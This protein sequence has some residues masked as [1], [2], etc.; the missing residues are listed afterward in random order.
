M[1]T[2]L[3]LRPD[4][5]FEGYAEAYAET[6][7]V[8]I[9]DIF[10]E[11][12][13]RYLAQLFREQ[14]AWRLIATD[15]RDN[16]VQFTQDQWRAL[17]EAERRRV[18]QGALA[19]AR[20]NRGFLYN[21]YQMIEAYLGRRDQGHP[22]HTLT[23][24]LNGPDWLGLGQAVLRNPAITKAD[25]HATLYAPG[26]Y[27]TRHTDLG[28]VRE[29][30]AAYVIGLTERWEADWGG[31]LLF[32]DE[33]GDV[34][35]GYAPRFNVVTIFDVEKVHLVTQV[36]NF[37]GAGRYSVAGWFRDDPPVRNAA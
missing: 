20:E 7:I 14:I 6:G 35:R 19:R 33:R 26:H 12:A 25:A 9:P 17:G 23:E 24:F 28:E 37:A 1:T 22:I 3:Y 31:L 2:D 16:P 4:I 27:L 5:D 13:A 10:A 29:R 32:L 15:E 11:P 8:Q 18:M 21:G 30:R 34:V 36:S